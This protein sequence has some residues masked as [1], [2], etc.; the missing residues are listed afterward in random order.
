MNATQWTDARDSSW[1]TL[2]LPENAISSVA[3][4]T[5]RSVYSAWCHLYGSLMVLNIIL[6]KDQVQKTVS[7]ATQLALFAFHT[8]A[9][10]VAPFLE[11]QFRVHPT[12]VALSFLL[13]PCR[14]VSTQ[15]ACRRSST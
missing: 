10:A 11:E 9:Q 5:M 13:A 3:W 15:T 1:L 7:N 14:T 2:P 8:P 12:S 4:W 6:A